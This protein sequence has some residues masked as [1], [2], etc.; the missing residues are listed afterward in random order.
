MKN[1]IQLGLVFFLFFCSIIFPQ[2]DKNVKLVVGIV[3]DQ[4]R[5]DYLYKFR[6]EFGN[7]GFNRLINEG[8]NFT[9]AHINYVPTYT[10]PGHAS[11]YTGTV[12]FYHGIVANDWFEERFPNQI[13]CTQDSTVKG[14]GYDGREGRMSPRRLL[15]TTITDQ[16]KLATNFKSKII[17]VSLKD[18]AAILPGGH[19]ADA[20][21][22]YE[23]ETGKFITSSYYM[24][25]LPKWVEDFNN[26]KLPEHYLSQTWELSKPFKEYNIF[27]SE[28]SPDKFD[29]HKDNN[30]K[31]PH[32]F[33]NT[34][35]I[36]KFEIFRYTPFGNQIIVDFVKAILQNEN[37]GK[38]NQTDFLAIS[39]SS[40][41]Y[42]GHEFGP[43]SLEVMDTYLKLDKQL[44]EIISLLDIQV[45]K[46][47]Y[48]LFLTS[49]H[50][51]A[52]ST[53]YLQSK[54]IH[55]ANL[56]PKIIMDSL[57]N[58]SKRKFSLDGIIRKLLNQQIFLN[59]SKIE[60]LGLKISE[61]ESELTKYLYLTFREIY[62]IQS[63]ESLEK[64]IAGRNTDNLI[65]N[66][67]YA[68]R[69]GNLFIQLLPGFQFNNGGDATTHAAIYNYDTHIPLIFYGWNIP[70]TEI[71]TPVYIEDIAPTIANLLHIQEPNG[72]IGKPLI[73][74]IT[75]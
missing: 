32:K 49:D 45:G 16:L 42:I 28:D 43:N 13:Y 30:F 22:W 25:Q 1:K 7:N 9:Y 73:N 47:N 60:S 50:G 24:N 62:L 51:V 71:N 48:L 61:V 2:T 59:E 72:C 29:I 15:T 37:L 38:N 40:T 27:S 70:H 26:K 8:T 66:G 39:F 10:G 36:Y 56:N 68:R 69:C 75:K 21:Y 63:R 67:F 74:I 54:K 35:S 33:D 53:E 4:M 31:F 20:A 52:E 44:E 19:T 6:N 17:A 12:P 11:I 64:I 23:N 14:L 58:F 3:I 5:F 65:L 46:G 34:S 55:G 18:R 41:D 57:K